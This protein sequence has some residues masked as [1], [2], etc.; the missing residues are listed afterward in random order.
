MPLTKLQFKPGINRETTSYSNEGGWF[1]GDKIRFRYGYPE[2]IGGWEKTSDV[3]FLGTARSLHPFTDLSGTDFLGLGT[4]LKYY[5]VEGLGSFNDITPIRQTFTSTATDN[6]FE[7]TDTSTTVTVNLTAHGAVDGDFVTFSG[8]TAVGGVPADELN[9]EHQLT[10]VDA[11]TF[12]IEVTT[13]ATS[14]VA[15]GGG[16]SITAA[17]QVNT[18]L[19][20]VVPG[21]GWGAGTWSRGTW[22]APSSI[23]LDTDQLRIW[24]HDNFGEDLLINIRDGDVFYWDSSASSP[25]SFQ[26]A[27]KLSTL[28]G[29][30]GYAPT[31]AKKVIV[32]DRDRHV[33]AFGCDPVDDLGTQDPL[34]IRFSNQEDPLTW[35]PTATNTAGDLRIGSGSKIVTA[36]ETRQQI[37]VITD[38][39]V[40]AMQYLG[41]PFTFGINQISENTTITGPLA[42][43]AVDDTV[44]WMGAQE[45]YIYSG[46][47]QR[48]PCTVR[49]Y[50][51]NDFNFDQKEKV[52]AALNSSFGEVWW[53]YPSSSSTEIDSYVVY[54]Y[55][56]QIWYYGTLARTAWIDRGINTNPIAT[57]TDGYL[58]NHEIGFDDGSTDPA[59]AITAHIESSQID[60]GDGDR[61]AF[62]R[63]LI[64]D[65]TFRDSTATS[66]TANFILKA[67]NFPGAAYDQSTTNDVV[68]SATVPV[69]QFTNQ[70]NTRLRG[71]SFAIRVE[72]DETEVTWRLGSPRV[73]IRP[74]GGR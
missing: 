59:T 43:V 6:C 70:V 9:A 41:P 37:L 64:P 36:V 25:G 35:F 27:E 21:T 26:R 13:A 72:S 69:E 51:F 22:G 1:D 3:Q 4:N 45:F 32:S 42:A 14:T 20:V 57:G 50:V 30:D 60:I 49:D 53:F 54:N 61:F 46:A 73:D 65:L 2:K 24:T 39:S 23:A 38:E 28:A 62:I 17:F 55:Q 44:F 67:R 48:L 18:G 15:S 5:I 71:R 52:F 31:I 74:D 7:T 10:F 8:A 33:I 66:P 68:Q 56:Q 34:L 47:V 40:H 12:T 29:A 16:T 63:R 11:N 19:T 58:Y